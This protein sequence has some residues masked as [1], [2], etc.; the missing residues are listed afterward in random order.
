MGFKGMRIN[1]KSFN[2]GREKRTRDDRLFVRFKQ[3]SNSRCTG[4]L[5]VAMIATSGLA[6]REQA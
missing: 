4:N 2:A 6:R 1:G 5:A 3:E